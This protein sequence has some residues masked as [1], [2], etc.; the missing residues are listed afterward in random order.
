MAI[1][2][3]TAAAPDWINKQ[4]IFQN[5]ALYTD[6]I[7]Q[8]NSTQVDD[9]K[10][11]DRVMPMYNLLEYSNNCS[12]DSIISGCSW[13][14]CRDNQITPRLGMTWIQMQIYK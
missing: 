12:V 4:L 11:L 1:T 13:H 9:A 5:F 14:Y 2:A 7:I 3:N 6:Y 10:D 8:M